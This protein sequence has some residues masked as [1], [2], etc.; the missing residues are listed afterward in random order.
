MILNSF[1]LPIP[2]RIYLFDETY[3]QHFLTSNEFQL[4]II[5]GYS[6]KFLLIC[7]F[8]FLTI[9]LKINVSKDA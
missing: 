4:I 3:V 1:P 6:L 7:E 2:G 8:L 5:F 9:A